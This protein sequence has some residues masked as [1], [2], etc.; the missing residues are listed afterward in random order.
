MEYTVNITISEKASVS[1]TGEKGGINR[2]IG[3]APGDLTNYRIIIL[4]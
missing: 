1:R 4:P 2:P 3:K